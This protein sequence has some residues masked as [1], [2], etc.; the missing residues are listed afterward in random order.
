MQ[1]L[2]L[3]KTQVAGLQRRLGKLGSQ[4]ESPPLEPSPVLPYAPPDRTRSRAEL[5]EERS[6]LQQ[7]ASPLQRLYAILVAA[8]LHLARLWSLHTCIFR[9]ARA[10]VCRSRFCEVFAIFRFYFRDFSLAL[11]RAS[12]I[13]KNTGVQKL[14]SRKIQVCRH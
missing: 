8:H 11:A 2:K 3:C 9:D 10:V 5:A 4:G 6:H 7:E 12:R 1:R 14:K 13:A